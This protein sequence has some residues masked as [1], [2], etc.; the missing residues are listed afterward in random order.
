MVR[1]HRSS[2]RGMQDELSTFCVFCFLEIIIM[3]YLWILTG[4]MSLLLTV[5]LFLMK[6]LKFKEASLFDL[7]AQTIR[8]NYLLS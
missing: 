2:V 5:W 1:M 8:T 3:I 6:N 7:L 4:L